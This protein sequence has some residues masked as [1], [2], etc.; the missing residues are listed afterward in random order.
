M[1]AV[2]NK[3][4]LLLGSNIEAELNIGRAIQRLGHIVRIEA[5]S[6]TWETLAV[7]STGPNFLNT[8]VEIMTELDV[9][10][11]KNGVLRPIEEE[12]GRKRSSDKNA[13]RT[14]DIDIVIFDGEVCDENLW[15]DVFRALP[16]AELLPDLRQLQTG[17]TLR[18]T[19]KR[20]Q[21]NSFAIAHPEL[22]NLSK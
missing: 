7:G 22:D 8:S 20:L 19:A 17:L 10:G 14:I 1:N 16:V 18:E 5:I 11:L 15:L 12:L 9:S 4:Y 13:P 3:A 2:L 21:Q 6:T